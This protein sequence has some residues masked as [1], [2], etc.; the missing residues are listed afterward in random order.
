M[1]TRLT[2]R[3]PRSRHDPPRGAAAGHLHR[4]H[5]PWCSLRSPPC[6]G[7]RGAHAP[8]SC[9]MLLHTSAF[10]AQMSN[11]FFDLQPGVDFVYDV[12][13]PEGYHKHPTTAATTL[14]HP[15]RVTLA[16]ST[17]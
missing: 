13:Y 9:V 15:Y 2:R 14:C 8:R 7:P 4:R 3:A 16:Y 5:L 11:S 6:D 17:K 1:L 12:C 10:H